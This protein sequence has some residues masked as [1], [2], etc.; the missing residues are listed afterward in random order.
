M[1]GGEAWF[2][3][4]TVNFPFSCKKF[5]VWIVNWFHENILYFLF[6]SYI[7]WCVCVCLLGFGCCIDRREESGEGKFLTLEEGHFII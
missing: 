4:D 2:H 3:E 5:T 1:K 7:D 6:S